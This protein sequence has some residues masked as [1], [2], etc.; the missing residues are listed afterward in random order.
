MGVSVCSG[1]K[2]ASE[3]V[4]GFLN[5]FVSRGGS[6]RS[7]CAAPHC[8]LEFFNALPQTTAQVGKFSWSKNDQDDQ[9][10]KK[11]VCW[12][13]QSFHNQAS[14][15]AHARADHPQSSFSIAQLPAESNQIYFRAPKTIFPGFL[16]SSLHWVK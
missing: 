1:R 15:P 5:F 4:L 3:L 6:I 8:I 16:P 12:L 11:Q 13:Q 14:G 2:R 9:E 7:G 10:N